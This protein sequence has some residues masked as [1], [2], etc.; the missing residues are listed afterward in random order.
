MP[1]NTILHIKNPVFDIEFKR[2]R[3]SND[4]TICAK[5]VKSRYKKNVFPPLS[6][7]FLSAETVKYDDKI[8]DNIDKKNIINFLKI[9][10][11]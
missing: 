6:S 3:T 4:S 5:A 9:C 7:P 1:K 11:F 8:T 10:S 2:E